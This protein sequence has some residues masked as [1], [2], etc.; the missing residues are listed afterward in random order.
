MKKKR[1]IF[2]LSLLLVAVGMTARA[3]VVPAMIVHGTNGQKQ[4]VQL[5]ATEVTDLVVLQSGQSL[6]VNI[7][8]AEVSGVRSLTFA[9]VEAE[10]IETA[11]ERTES[12]LIRNVEKVVRDGQVLIRL[13]T[14]NGSVIEYDV[15]GNR[16]T[17]KG[18][19]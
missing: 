5:A 15:R 12:P 11:V 7:P 14:E 13:Q 1:R 19:N 3:S 17:M 10:E 8:E 18:E 16:I 9:M 6:Q 4:V 2:I